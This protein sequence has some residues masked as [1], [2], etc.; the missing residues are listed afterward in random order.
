M[1]LSP[2]NWGSSVFNVWV[3]TILLNEQLQVPTEVVNYVGEDLGYYRY[4]SHTLSY[5]RPAYNF[6]GIERGSQS[7]SCAGYPKQPTT[8]DNECTHAQ[9][10]ICRSA[11]RK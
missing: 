5:T 7:F 4:D 8:L 1:R 2:S 11:K 6:A 9:L 10:E 3:A